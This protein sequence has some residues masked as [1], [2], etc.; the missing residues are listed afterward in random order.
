MYLMYI[1]HPVLLNMR[2]ENMLEECVLFCFVL[3][4]V[5]NVLETG[6]HG[7]KHGVCHKRRAEY[8]YRM[9]KYVKEKK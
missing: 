3:F 5:E 2:N 6:E 1:K 7:K 9:N 8:I 4:W